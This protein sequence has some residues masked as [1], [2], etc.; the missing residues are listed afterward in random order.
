[1]AQKSGAGEVR[2]DGGRVPYDLRR[3][4]RSFGWRGLD[5]SVDYLFIVKVFSQL[6]AVEIRGTCIRYK[7][8]P[9]VSLVYIF[10]GCSPYS[11]RKTIYIHSIA[12]IRM[13]LNLI[14]RWVKNRLHYNRS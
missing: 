14:Q 10:N 8:F 3:C 1:M 11:S 4:V 12:S 2:N 9:A 7:L 5:E 6:A 13:V